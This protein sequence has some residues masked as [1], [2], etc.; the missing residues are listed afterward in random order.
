MGHTARLM[1]PQF[2]KP[3]VK[4]NKNDAADAEAICGAVGRP[5]MRFVPVKNAGQQAVLSMHRAREG[6]VKARTA[7]ANPIRGL[8]AEYG[9]V[10]PQGICNIARPRRRSWRTPGMFREP[11]R[12]LGGHSSRPG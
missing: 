4:T 12:R 2:V 8:L 9:I 10:M 1:A 6:F 3:Y 11:L 5:T 7:Q